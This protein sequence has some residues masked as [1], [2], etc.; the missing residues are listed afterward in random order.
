MAD[1]LL[2]LYSTPSFDRSLTG[3]VHLEW[4]VGAKNVDRK[5]FEGINTFHTTDCKVMWVKVHLWEVY[6]GIKSNKHYCITLE[7]N[8]QS[9]NRNL[10]AKFQMV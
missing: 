5:V 3:E 1:F 2:L 9:V 6:I 10:N 8:S 7:M 4:S